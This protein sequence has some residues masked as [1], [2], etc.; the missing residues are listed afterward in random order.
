MYGFSLQKRKREIIDK[1]VDEIE[2]FYRK[3]TQCAS[4]CDYLSNW[5]WRKMRCTDHM[6]IF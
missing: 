1:P 6:K 2:I 4:V 3:L 5:L